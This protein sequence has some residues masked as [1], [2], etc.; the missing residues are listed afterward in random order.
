MTSP[1]NNAVT[2]VTGGAGFLG[3]HLIDSLLQDGHSVLCVDSLQTG[4]LV[5]IQHLSANP[6]FEFLEHD[7]CQP[8]E[9]D[10]RVA[11]IYNL[12]CPASPVHYQR[13]PVKTMKT[14]VL[15]MLTM[16]DLA[17]QHNCPIL[18]ASTSE[19]YGDP[20]VHP[21]TEDYCG[22]VNPTGIRACYDEGKRC[23]E[24]LCFD[25]HRQFGVAIKVVRIFNAYGPRMRPDDGRVVSNFVVQALKGESLT[26]YGDG[27]QS[28][29][30]C[31]VD[32][33]VSAIRKA[34]D[35][36]PKFTGPVNIGNPNDFTMLEL[37][38]RVREISGSSS[39]LVH[40][41]LPKDDPKQRCPDTTLAKEML[42]W[43]PKVELAEGLRHTIEYFRQL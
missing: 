25:Y 27:K 2:V 10:Q 36:D 5:N 43:T 22:R 9:I 16:L 4:S 33:L 32:D 38:N 26:V 24:A 14:C 3:S 6:K 8:L 37:A 17:K 30:F 11:A 19:V 1:S 42:G 21:Q 20:D 13:N 15:G 41:P 39:E 23:A 29:S 12:A 28:R 31:Y 34:M 7:I 35:S 40:Y 18:Q